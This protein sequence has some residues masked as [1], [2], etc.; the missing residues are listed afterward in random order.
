MIF[1]QIIQKMDA[2]FRNLRDHVFCR[3]QPSSVHGVGVFAVKDIPAN[4]YPFLLTNG[5]QVMEK[6]VV[7]RE[8]DTTRLDLAVV[9]L[10]DDFYH[11]ENGIYVIPYNGLN[12]NNISFYMNTSDTPNVGFEYQRNSDFVVFKTKS[13]IKKGEELLIDYREF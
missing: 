1:P 9:A 13:C 5:R 11:K 10:L 4:T 8:E 6:S 7:L 12:S 3:I 2:V